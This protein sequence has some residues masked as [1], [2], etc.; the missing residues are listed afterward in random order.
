MSRVAVLLLAL[1]LCACSPSPD[2][3]SPALWRVDG[4]G[5]QRAWLFGTIHALERPVLW[6]S[7]S[8][9]AALV[10]ADRIVVEVADQKAIPAAFTRRA[11]APGLPPLS[12]R[13]DPA[14]RPALATLLDEA[15][16]SESQFATT[17]TWAV[18]LS[19]AR[20]GGGRLDPKHGVDRAVVAAASGKPVVE[21]EGADGQLAVFDDLPEREQRDLLATVLRD[22]GSLQT[23]SGSLAAAWR[24]GDMATIERETHRGLLADPELREALFTQ[25]NRRWAD[26]IAAML[27]SGQRPFVAVG[28]AHM[29]GADGLPAML[30][31]RGLRV[32]RVQ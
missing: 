7:A 9:D 13:V 14:L 30:E 31:A 29:A 17:E 32:A 4:P 24:K 19:L 21:L 12:A 26:R 28:G 10:E 16:A 2:P 23:E 15:D 8:V 3:A 11:N 25:R 20:A 1:L 18:A 6:R 22:A 5:G 27:A